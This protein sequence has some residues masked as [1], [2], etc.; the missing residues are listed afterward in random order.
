MGHPMSSGGGCGCTSNPF[1]DCLA[2]RGGQSPLCPEPFLDGSDAT[3]RGCRAIR[4]R[5]SQHRLGNPGYHLAAR[6]IRNL[7]G[8]VSPG[9]SESGHCRAAQGGQSVVRPGGGC[10]FQGS[11]LAL[12]GALC[13]PR[14][15]AVLL[16]FGSTPGSPGRETW[17]LWNLG[18]G[19][20]GVRLVQSPA[21]PRGCE[22]GW[23]HLLPHHHT[24]GSASLS[25]RGGAGRLADAVVLAGWDLGT[26]GKTPGTLQRRCAAGQSQGR[27]RW[28]LHPGAHDGSAGFS[29]RCGLLRIFPPRGRHLDRPGPPRPHHQQRC[30]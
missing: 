29:G 18:D 17:A 11:T 10:L 26:C 15:P 9:F 3:H 1:G 23:Q 30:P 13:Q 21:A 27:S 6:W 7:C 2:I 24:S 28:A 4:A 22:R 5:E 8:G 14:W 20:G 12:P 19:K 16:R 25:T